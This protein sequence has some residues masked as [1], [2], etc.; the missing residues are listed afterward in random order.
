MTESINQLITLCTQ[1]APGQKECDNAL[2][3]LEVGPWVPGKAAED[4][5]EG[6]SVSVCLSVFVC[7]CSFPI[8]LVFSS[9]S[10]PFIFPRRLLR[11]KF[12]SKWKETEDKL[13]L[14]GIIVPASHFSS[15]RRYIL[16]KD[17]LFQTGR[18]L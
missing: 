14:V 18:G 5:R 11:P 3:E 16:L 13:D 15:R 10:L 7:V 2:R 1:Q 9:L 6:V 4:L 12:Q 8:G 17:S